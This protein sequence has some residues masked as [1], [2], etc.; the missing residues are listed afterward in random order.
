MET[1]HTL[2]VF[3]SHALDFKESY[4]AADMVLPQ[5]MYMGDILH[6]AETVEKAVRVRKDLSRVL[7]GASFRPQKWC[8]N[9]TEIL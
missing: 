1:E 4:L 7:G 6:S 8:S 3:C 9:R 5:D 2:L